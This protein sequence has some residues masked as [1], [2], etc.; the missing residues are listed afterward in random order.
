MLAIPMFCRLLEDRV[1][2]G[3]FGSFFFVVAI[4]G[5]N[6]AKTQKK[7]KDY[8]DIQRGEEDGMF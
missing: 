3:D 8:S 4:L 6:L 2:K 5:G 7:N 1:D